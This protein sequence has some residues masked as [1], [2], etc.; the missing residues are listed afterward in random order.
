MT[1]TRGD[2]VVAAFP[3]DLGKPRPAVIVQATLFA[4]AFSTILA[5]PLTSDVIDAPLLRPIIEPTAQNGLQKRSQIMAEKVYPLKKDVIK[6]RIGSLTAAEM[7]R[8]D[9][10]LSLLMGLPALPIAVNETNGTQESP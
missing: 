2:M 3:G 8:L 9:I 4:K 1:F 7:S 6:Q 5:C 10:A